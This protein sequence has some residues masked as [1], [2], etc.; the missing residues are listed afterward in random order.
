MADQMLE[1][2][3][4]AFEGQIDF[5]GQ[6]LSELITTVLLGAAGIIAFIVGYINQDI[7]QTLW[8]GL[9]GTTLTF[10][11]VVPPWPFYNK[12]PLPW[13]PPHNAISG[14]DIEVDGKRV[15]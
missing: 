11:A 2:V 15:G 14:L 6:R 8:I 9:A 5:E 12:N 3:R 4:D 13:L 10:F 1:K 7:Y